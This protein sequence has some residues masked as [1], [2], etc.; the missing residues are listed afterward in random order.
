MYTTL[1]MLEQINDVF[2]TRKVVLHTTLVTKVFCNEFASRMRLKSY[3]GAILQA[4]N[5]ESCPSRQQMREI[6]R[7]R[8]IFPVTNGRLL[9]DQYCW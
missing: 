7:V 2:G 9:N 5:L 4:T 1:V 3:E 6:H 8:E